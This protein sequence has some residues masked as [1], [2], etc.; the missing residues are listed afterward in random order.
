MSTL[1]DRIFSE[2]TLQ[3]ILAI[4]VT[5]GCFASYFV[6]HDVPTWALQLLT[7]IYGFFFGSRLGMSQ[8]RSQKTLNGGA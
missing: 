7:L 3:G 4:I 2:A 1:V 6:Y 8:S 5:L